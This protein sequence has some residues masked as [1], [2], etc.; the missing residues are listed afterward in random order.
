[1]DDQ[2][3]RLPADCLPRLASGRA[4][5]ETDRGPKSA[6]GSRGIV[7][8]RVRG[9]QDYASR[10]EAVVRHQLAA[11][12]AALIGYDFA[13]KYDAAARYAGP[14]Y[15]VPSDTLV[16]LEAMEAVGICGEHDLFGGVVPYR[17]AATKVITHP[18]VE[19]D[20]FAPE[21]WSRVFSRRIGDIVHTGFS[22][23]TPED[24]HRAG[25][26]LLES[27]AV[28]LKPARAAGGR[29]QAVVSTHSELETA[30]CA[31]DPT[32][33]SGW[34]LV[35]E[36]NLSEVTTYSVGQVRVADL[37]ASYYGRQR[38][39]P[40]NGGA[41]VYGGSDLV[42]VRGGFETLLGLDL[43][44]DVRLAILQGQAYDVAAMDCFTGMF[45]SR[46]NYDV[47]RG[48]DAEGHWRSGVIEQSWRIGGA[49]GAEIAA[50]EAFRADPL[51]RSVRAST[52]EAY[53]ETEPPP[54]D[55][56]VYFQGA[57]EQVGLITKYVLLERNGSGFFTND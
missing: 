45:A 4:G 44:E 18:L 57:D 8:A 49:S 36:E 33:L 2:P 11:K 41:L 35:I 32:E 14:M 53:G 16:G 31:M 50:L 40:D 15:F 13:G 52:V 25:C 7:V 55:A 42:V 3:N 9:T 1:M 19:P 51:L 23:F 47:A 24:A 6:R 54:P 22:V 5:T 48:I 56:I 10:H 43:P 12:L 26:L 27:G 28:R 46:R 17:F 39:T 20:A 38:L 34:G 37:V 30:L 29:G 21:G